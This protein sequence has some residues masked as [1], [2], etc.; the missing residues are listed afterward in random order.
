MDRLPGAGYRDAVANT[1][2]VPRVQ[3]QPSLPGPGA[4]GAVGFDASFSGAQRI[5][6][7][8]SAWV[9]HVAGWVHGADD[10]FA[11][12]LAR[13]PWEHRRVTMYGRVLDEPRLTAWYGDGLDA[14]TVPDT[15]REMA[16]ALGARYQRAFDGIGAAL[17]RD[18]RDSV[19]WHADRIDPALVEPVVAIVSL[20][21]R[22]VLRL[23]P[24]PPARGDGRAVEL[25]PGDL[26]VMGGQS[27]RTWQ[28]AVPKVA[29]AGPRISLQFRHAR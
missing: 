17:Y 21:S 3:W 7:D 16:A 26:F 4:P 10:L 29:R 8:A 12:L 2:S 23:R 25:A 24:M 6:L 1:C 14:P 9:E 5:A 27:Q 22:R 11:S 20:G 13:A 28:H 15:A 18:G 19:A